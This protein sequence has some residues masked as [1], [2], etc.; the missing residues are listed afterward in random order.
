MSTMSDCRCGVCADDLT[1][2]RIRC[3]S[4]QYSRIP[5]ILSKFSNSEI[6]YVQFIC[7]TSQH[8]LS[9]CLGGACSIQKADFF[10]ALAALSLWRSV[11]RCGALSAQAHHSGAHRSVLQ[12]HHSGAHKTEFIQRSG[13]HQVLRRSSSTPVLWHSQML[14]H[15]QV[16]RHSRVLRHH[17]CCGILRLSGTHQCTGIHRCS[18]TP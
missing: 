9:S 1:D 10:P 16:L 4:L 17:T 18:G 13:A 15:S 2:E 5:G 11:R 3:I 7:S 8:W 12:A 6:R 14:R